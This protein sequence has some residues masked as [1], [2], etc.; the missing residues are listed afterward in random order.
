MLTGLLHVIISWRLWIRRC[1]A[2][3]D[4]I[5]EIIESVW[6]LIKHWTRNTNEN[7]EKIESEKIQ[8][9]MDEI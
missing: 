7:M 9:I 4:N 1:R 5:Y 2:R 3:M 6:L 8:F